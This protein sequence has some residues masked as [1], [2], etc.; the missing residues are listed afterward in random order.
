MS[1]YEDG[2]CGFAYHK[3]AIFTVE[4]GSLVENGFD[5]GLDKYPIF[6]ESYREPLNAKIIEHFFFREIGLETPGLF[7]RFLN[8]RMNEV[9]PYYNQLY[10]SA[11]REFDPFQNYD[12]TTEGSST[13]TSDQTRDY[14]RTESTSTV[15]K[16]DTSSDTESDARTLVSNTPQMQLSGREDYASNIT[17]SRSKTEAI[18]TSEQASSADTA[19]SDM[20]AA[21]AKTLDEYVTRVSGLSG[22]TASNALLQFRETFL[23]IDMLVIGELNDL[24]MGIYT[25]YWN[26][27]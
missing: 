14:S 6:D 8:R 24:F 10:M 22:I 4:L 18:G 15:A 23:N 9:M 2:E 21:S 27:L 11:L 3:G 5:L 12:M 1:V 16:S 26:A 20:T 17:D 7:K 25:D 19:A 13:G